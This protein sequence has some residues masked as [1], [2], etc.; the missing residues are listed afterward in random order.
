[1][2]EIWLLQ[3]KTINTNII[4]IKNINNIK[5]QIKI[6]SEIIF[7][8]MCGICCESLFNDFN[9]HKCIH[10]HKYTH[11]ICLH[12]WLTKKSNKGK[13]LPCIYCKC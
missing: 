12:R 2:W 7:S 3:D 9:L 13:I 11:N 10:C 8:D 5:K 6:D 1:M 4:P